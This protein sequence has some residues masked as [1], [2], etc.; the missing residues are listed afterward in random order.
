MINDKCLHCGSKEFEEYSQGPD[1]AVF[2]EHKKGLFKERKTLY[3]E[4]CKDC[5]TV[6]RIY[7]IQK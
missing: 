2:S 6:K 1:A 3:Y 7:V 5:G 4:I